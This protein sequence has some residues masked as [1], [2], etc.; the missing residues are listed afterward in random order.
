MLGGSMKDC[1][2]YDVGV[3]R[4]LVKIITKVKKIGITN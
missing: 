4:F 1:C 3:T 2:G